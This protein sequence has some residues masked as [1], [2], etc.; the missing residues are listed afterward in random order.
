ML[1]GKVAEG[2]M[3]MIYRAIA[4]E[5][6]ELCAVKISRWIKALKELR[7][8]KEEDARRE[9]V[10]RVE[11]EF[12]LLEKASSLSQHIV[13]V[14]GEYGMD[15]RVGLYYPMEFLQGVLLSGHPLFGTPFP[16]EQVL[17][18]MLQLCDALG[19]A[20]G[21]GVVH[22]DLNPDNIFIVRYE[23]R[24]FIKLIDF[25]I[26]RNLY[27]RR[28]LFDTGESLGFGHLHYLS[29]EQ[30]GYSAREQRYDSEVTRHLDHRADIFSLGGIM[31][32]MLTGYP[33]YETETFE[34]LAMREW[35]TPHNLERSLAEGL[36]PHNLKD[37]IQSCLE[38][39]P[40]RRPP[41]LY[42]LTDMLRRALRKLRGTPSNEGIAFLLEPGPS[43]DGAEFDD[44]FGSLHEEV[45]DLLEGFSQDALSATP[46]PSPVPPPPPPAAKARKAPPPPPP[47]AATQ[48]KGPTQQGGQNTK[49]PQTHQPSAAAQETEG[50]S[51]KLIFILLG[52]ALL[53]VALGIGVLFSK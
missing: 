17:E 10:A 18:L 32:H 12:T 16:P 2:G 4:I 42:V 50:S 9:E 21:L 3:G 23:Q 7:Q 6:N 26:A 14:H 5:N 34:D 22:R 27:H 35:E 37:L 29:P 25:G 48:N 52:I 47:P 8:L 36:L 11:R 46:A 13:Q 15:P 19:V 40:D 30:V 31:F 53:F 41:D 38:A 24:E 49:Q 45:G 28:K 1:L 20:H 39:D 43:D 51:K 44:A 33:P